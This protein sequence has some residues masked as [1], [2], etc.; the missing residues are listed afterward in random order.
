MEMHL[1]TELGSGTSATSTFSQHT[2][3][4]FK[5][6]KMWNL[7]SGRFNIFFLQDDME[8]NLEL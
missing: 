8:I 1:F 6:L 7:F 3:Y 5:K 4:I 2:V